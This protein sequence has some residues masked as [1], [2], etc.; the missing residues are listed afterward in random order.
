M[1]DI[2]LL[3]I[4]LSVINIGLRVAGF[5]ISEDKLQ[6]HWVQHLNHYAPSLIFFCLALFSTFGNTLEVAQWWKIFPLIVAAIT[7]IIGK[8]MG[9]TLTVSML[10]YAFISNYL[11]L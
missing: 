9:I 4:T 1:Q 2:T 7:H 8:N 6:Q 3:I 10:S 11:I 5:I